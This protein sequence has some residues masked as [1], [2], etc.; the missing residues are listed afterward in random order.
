MIVEVTV[1]PNSRGFSLSIKNGRIRIALKS[2]PEN[3]R[4]NIELI[5]ELSRLTGSGVRILSGAGSKRKTL[6]IGIS[7]EEWE[8]LLTD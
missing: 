5:R 8:R 7:K 3:N 6:E 2:P 4:A 1:A